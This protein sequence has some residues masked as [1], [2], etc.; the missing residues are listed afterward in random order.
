MSTGQTLGYVILS[1]KGLATEAYWTWLG[2]IGLL[3]MLMVF[4]AAAIL[5]MAYIDHSHG[6]QGGDTRGKPQVGGEWHNDHIV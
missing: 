5:A 3:V 2:I 4:V 1:S 6:G